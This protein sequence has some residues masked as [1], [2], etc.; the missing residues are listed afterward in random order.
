VRLIWAI[1]LTALVSGCAHNP[2]PPPPATAYVLTWGNPNTIPAC[3]TP[4]V[5][6]C[7]LSQTVNSQ[8]VAISA[9]TYPAT[10]G[11]TYQVII[12]SYNPAGVLV[13]SKPAT[14]TVP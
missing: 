2:P 1:A 4:P 8:T 12:N 3:A 9:R 10:A 7:Q 11:T 13:S 6:P 14:V 5:F